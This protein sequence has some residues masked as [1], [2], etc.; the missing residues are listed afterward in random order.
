MAELGARRRG[1]VALGLSAG[2]LLGLSACA[3][4]PGTVPDSV[5][6]APGKGNTS[7]D[8]DSESKGGEGSSWQT[9]N[10]PEVDEKHTTLP[11]SFPTESFPLPADAQIYDAGERGEGVWFVVLRADTTDSAQQLMDAIVSGG[12][13]TLSGEAD[14]SD[15]GKSAT[16]TSSTLTGQLLTIPQ[17][18]GSVL[19]NYDLR[20][21]G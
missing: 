6:G 2:L 8:S 11:T 14:A 19:L 18:D 15:G 4:E 9:P 20:R 10:P 5:A 16:L 21:A 12:G 7:G 1:L 3:P 13:F 17:K